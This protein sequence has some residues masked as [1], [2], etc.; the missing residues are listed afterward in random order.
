MW[1]ANDWRLILN[2]GSLDNWR[3]SRLVDFWRAHDLD[4]LLDPL[5]HDFDPFLG[6]VYVALPVELQL[7]LS[8]LSFA[9]PSPL[10]LVELW[11]GLPRKNVKSN[12]NKIAM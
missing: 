3:L 1:G 9:K 8:V 11:L 12:V 10:R 4:H 7:N 2:N 6:E 5:T